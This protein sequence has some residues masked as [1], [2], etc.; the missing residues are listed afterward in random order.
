MSS[1]S[2]TFSP[3]SPLRRIFC[4]HTSYWVIVSGTPAAFT[5]KW[6][7]VIAI[8]PPV[9]AISTPALLSKR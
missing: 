6:F 4:R 2:L 9:A 5:A 7:E 8:A 3:A 1:F